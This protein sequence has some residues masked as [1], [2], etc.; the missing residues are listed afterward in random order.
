LA[1]DKGESKEPSPFKVNPQGL[2]HPK[3][4][5]L[6]KDTWALLTNEGGG[7]MPQLQKNL[8]NV[9]G[10]SKHWCCENFED[11]SLQVK[12]I[13]QQITTLHDQ[14]SLIIP[15]LEWKQALEE[16]ERERHLLQA[17]EEAHQGMKRRVI[18]L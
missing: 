16:L 11:A 10:V 18:W 2:K 3:Y 6:A 4:I 5:Q 17:W 15:T 14:V 12:T 1:L 7:Y 9:K 8:I 13:E